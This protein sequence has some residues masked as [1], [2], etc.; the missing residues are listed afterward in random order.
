MKKSREKDVSNDRTEVCAGL[1]TQARAIRAWHTKETNRDMWKTKSLWWWSTSC[2]KRKDQSVC[3]TSLSFSNSSP[4]TWFDPLLPFLLHPI[5]QLNL[6]RI[7]LPPRCALVPKDSGW[8]ISTWF[9]TKELIVMWLRSGKTSSKPLVFA[10]CAFCASDVVFVHV[11]R[12]NWN[13]T[14]IF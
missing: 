8:L 5:L 14:R 2:G 11:G 4:R 9:Q 7:D 6:M 1:T 10:L 3:S 13:R 12:R